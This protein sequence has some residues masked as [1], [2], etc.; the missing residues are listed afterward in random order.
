MWIIL[1]VLAVPLIEIALF[2]TLGAAIGLWLTL[3]WIFLTGALGVILLKGV[4]T[5]G[6]D[7]MATGIREEMNDPLSPLAHRFLVGIAGLLLLLPG[8]FTDAIGLLLLFPPLRRLFIAFVKRRMG[9]SVVMH[10][11]VVEGDWRDVTPEDDPRL[12]PH[13]DGTRH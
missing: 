13:R 8:F 6:I 10:S 7:R 3:A 5:L 9:G 12:P 4:A 1:G 11:T 2:V